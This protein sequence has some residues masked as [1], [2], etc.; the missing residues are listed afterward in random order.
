MRASREAKSETKPYVRPT[1]DGLALGSFLHYL[2][3]ECRLSPH[4]LAAY[5]SD[6]A[7][8]LRWKRAI[9]RPL[10]HLTAGDLRSYVDH[11]ATA[12]LAPASIARHLA[13]LSTYCRYLMLEGELH[14]NLAKLVSSP[15]LWDRL[16]GVLSPT[17][18][19][20]LLQASPAGTPLGIR[21]K[22]LL[23]TLYASGCRASEVVGLK[24][25]DLDLTTGIARCIGK[26]DKERVVP[27]G[28]AAKSALVRYLR[29][30]RP[31]LARGRIEETAVFLTRGGRPLSRIGL[32]H[33]VRQVAR[34]AGLPSHVSPHTLRHSFATHL[35][36]GGA[37]LRVVQEILGHASIATTQIYTRV[38]ISRLQQVHRRVHPRN[39]R[40]S[41][42][43][44]PRA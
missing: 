43:T 33:V 37:D 20:A 40:K 26:G 41:A 13:S 3:A 6:I 11:L 34:R 12:G 28:A 7:R 44:K 1:A 9:A 10:E 4:T 23:E 18:V 19:E 17:A 29:E 25:K 21:D 36:S 15:K 38:D 30:S 27:L 32:W 22:A 31:I 14:E 35:L 2:M 8:F 16:P 39:L 5:R 24:L 42:P